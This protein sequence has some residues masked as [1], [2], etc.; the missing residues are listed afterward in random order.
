MQ[1]VMEDFILLAIIIQE[2]IERK[3]CEEAN[4]KILVVDNTFEQR[5]TQ[6]GYKK[7]QCTYN[8]EIIEVIPDYRIEYF[9]SEN[10]DIDLLYP[11]QI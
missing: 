7:L 10:E 5:A 4:L 2:N 8:I 6:N 3:I 1:F 9:L 11:L